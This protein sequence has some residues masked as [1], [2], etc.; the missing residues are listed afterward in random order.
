MITQAKVLFTFYVGVTFSRLFQYKI[1][2]V[3]VPLDG[4]IVKFNI[5][6]RNSGAATLILASNVLPNVNGSGLVVNLVDDNFL[7]TLAK[8]DIA[9]LN[10][11]VGSWWITIDE[12][13]G[14]L[15]VKGNGTIEIKSL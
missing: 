9:I 5:G 4:K 12:G 13:D 8:E 7:V 11:E 2:N 15:K 14:L 6:P 10:F 3:A 1:A